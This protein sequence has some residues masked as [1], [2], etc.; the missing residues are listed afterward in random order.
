MN[1]LDSRSHGLL[2]YLTAGFLFLLPRALRWNRSMTNVL[3]GAS[4]VTFLYSALTRYDYGLLKLLP[5]RIHLGLDAM[6]GAMFCMS[7]LFFRKHSKLVQATMIGIGIF[8]LA[9][10]LATDDDTE[11]S[12]EQPIEFKQYEG[13]L[14]EYSP[15]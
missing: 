3:T 11:E 9:A 7:P 2:D 5:F 14:R 4:L 12:I 8:E 6:S 10:T 15:I 13:E 1:K